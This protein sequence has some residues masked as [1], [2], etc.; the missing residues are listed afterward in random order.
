[1]VVVVVV[2]VALARLEAGTNDIITF[3]GDDDDDVGVDPLTE[4]RR[5]FG[6]IFGDNGDSNEDLGLFRFTF[7]DDLGL[8]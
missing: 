2:V 5:L 8:F 7:G 6:I 1:V 4:G 3:F